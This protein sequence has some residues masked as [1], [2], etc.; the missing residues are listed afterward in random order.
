MD[1]SLSARQQQSIRA[2]SWVSVPGA[3][4]TSI[5]NNHAKPE[6]VPVM[7]FTGMVL[8]N[9]QVSSIILSQK[10][11]SVHPNIVKSRES[12]HI[13][14]NRTFLPRMFAISKSW[15]IV[16]NR[17]KSWKKVVQW[18]PGLSLYNQDFVPMDLH[19][20]HAWFYF[21][22]S[23][24]CH[25]KDYTRREMGTLAFFISI[26]NVYWDIVRLAGG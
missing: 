8:S 17:E 7:Q 6:N 26:H 12:Q 4:I 2:S 25:F 24:K 10:S 18:A 16:W 3:M 14:E 1:Q 20:T 15:R 22:N 19:V 13:A 21:L 11:C 5:V 9:R 23:Q